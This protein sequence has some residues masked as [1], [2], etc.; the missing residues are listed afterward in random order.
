M[1]AGLVQQSL[2]PRVVCTS[3][4]PPKH[5]PRPLHLRYLEQGPLNYLTDKLT[6]IPQRS[7]LFSQPRSLGQRLPD[8]SGTN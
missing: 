3:S 4:A 2:K 8:C 7:V 5:C 1:D 6:I